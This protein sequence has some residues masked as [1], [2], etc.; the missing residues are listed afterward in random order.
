MKHRE[1]RRILVPVVAVFLGFLVG[2]FVIVVTGRSPVVL[3]TSLI[4]TLTGVDPSGFSDFNPRYVGEFIVQALPIILTGLSVAF[5]FRTGLFNIGAEG[6]LMIG[7]LAAVA[8]ALLVQ[9]P[10]VV[11][12]VLCLLAAIT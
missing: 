9:A 1:Q 7:S 2:A 12:T 8:V 5:A 4:R 11:H 3:F 10:P 6:Q